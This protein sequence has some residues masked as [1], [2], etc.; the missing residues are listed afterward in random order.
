VFGEGRGMNDGAT[1]ALDLSRHLFGS[2]RALFGVLVEP[3]LDVETNRRFGIE[4]EGLLP[5]FNRLRRHPV[6]WTP[7]T[8]VDQKR[9]EFAPFRF[10]VRH[11][12]AALISAP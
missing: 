7:G 5:E 2:P 11:P 3:Q 12:C 4:P 6:L 10:S 9:E 1:H 8:D